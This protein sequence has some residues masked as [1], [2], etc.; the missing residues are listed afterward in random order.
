[1]APFDCTMRMTTSDAGSPSDWMMTFD[2]SSYDNQEGIEAPRYGSSFPLVRTADARAAPVR[3]LIPTMKSKCGCLG[4]VPETTQSNW[5]TGSTSDLACMWPASLQFGLNA[6]VTPRHRR[7]VQQSV[8]L[9]LRGPVT[10]LPEGSRVRRVLRQ[11]LV[12]ELP[13]AD[14]PSRSRQLFVVT[15]AQGPSISKMD[16]H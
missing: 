13:V 7:V 9:D 10:T 3:M 11:L 6:D 1:M 8:L 16:R 5:I 4:C 14:H 12:R 15:P 2:C